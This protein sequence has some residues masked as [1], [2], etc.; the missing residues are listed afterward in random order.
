MEKRFWFGFFVLGILMI[1]MSSGVLGVTSYKLVTTT[2]C[3]GGGPPAVVYQYG[4]LAC[5]DSSKFCVNMQRSVNECSSSAYEQ[6][7]AYINCDFNLFIN[8][9]PDSRYY[10]AVCEDCPNPGSTVGCSGGEICTSGVQGNVCSPG[11]QFHVF[12]IDSSNNAVIQNAAVEIHATSSPSSAIVYT[13]LTDS[14]GRTP[15]GSG[16]ANIL[17]GS[18]YVEVRKTGYV[19]KTHVE[20]ITGTTHAWLESLSA[21]CTSHSYQQCSAGDVYWYDSCDVKEDVAVPC[22]GNGCT[23][24]TCDQP[25]GTCDACS[26]WVDSSCGTGSNGCNVGNRI[27]TRNCPTGTCSEV[28][29]VPDAS[30]SGSGSG[31]GGN[32]ECTSDSDCGGSQPICDLNVGSNNYQECVE[33]ASHSDC[34]Q[35]FNR[36]HPSGFCQP[37]G[38][39]GETCC[40]LGSQCQSGLTCDVFP[41]GT[42]SGPGSG[43][44]GGGSSCN[45]IDSDVNWVYK[46]K[47]VDS[48]VEGT[49]VELEINAV[50][51]CSGTEVLEW[52]IQDDQGDS[53]LDVLDDISSPYLDED[54][55][56]SYDW[57]A[58]FGDAY[59]FKVT[60]NGQSSVFSSELDVV[61]ACYQTTEGEFISNC[62]DYNDYSDSERGPEEACVQ[63][64]AG[65]GVRQGGK[66]RWDASDGC[67]FSNYGV[68]GENEG[69]YC[70]QNY[71]SI[72]ECSADQAYRTIVT[73]ISKRNE[74]TGLE[75][76]DGSSD[77]FGSC[78]GAECEIQ[79]ACPRFA[80]LPFFTFRNVIGVLIIIAIGYVLWWKAKEEDSKRRKK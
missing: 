41:G 60:L 76:N 72:G 79:S 22:G 11:T 57:E 30:C 4:N 59:V 56:L 15:G 34:E 53:F 27:Q 65:V 17:S 32:P 49:D 66:C 51:Y 25:V 33:C 63:D 71:T 73:T 26:A 48:V 54:G 61:E 74:S 13:G 20:S 75:I 47:V 24:N 21:G 8:E 31:G 23:G 12:V 64:C 69:Y 10:R 19:T 58:E 16:W 1:F 7:P 35:P 52:E 77:C 45:I 46:G 6:A 42:C 40:E 36:C 80:Q 29:C 70:R 38:D 5:E 37:C 78:G 39:S 50:N 43:G 14:N 18:H 55:E 2:S 62:V 3:S 67:F 28:N 44:G 68:N 9:L